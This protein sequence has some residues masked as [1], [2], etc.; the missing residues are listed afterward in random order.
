MIHHPVQS[1]FLGTIPM[2][3]ATLVI[4]ACHVCLPQYGDGCVPCR[5]E[6]TIYELTRFDRMLYFVWTLWWIDSVVAVA[7]A[8]GLPFMM[9]VFAARHS[10]RDGIPLR[11]LGRFTRQIHETANMTAVW[12]LPIVGPNVSA[13]AGAVVAEYLPAHHAV[14]TIHLRYACLGFLLPYR[15]LADCG[16]Q[17]PHAWPLH[18]PSLDDHGALLQ[19]PRSAQG[20]E[21]F[22]ALR[23]AVSSEPF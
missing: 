2:G 23:D 21:N 14:M 20:E 1:M 17:L 7:I 3:F 19:P 18:L 5:S 15:A 9:C 22:Q 13:S 4:M 6:C 11:L 16:L 8:L 12:L 10:H